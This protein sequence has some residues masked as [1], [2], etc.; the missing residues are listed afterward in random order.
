MEPNWIEIIGQ[1]AG[2]LSV[3]D[4]P[5]DF[6][7]PPG[8]ILE[9]YGWLLV[10]PDGT[11][12]MVPVC[13]KYETG[14]WKK[15]CAWYSAPLFSTS[16]MWPGNED[17]APWVRSEMRLPEGDG[18]VLAFDRNG[19]SLEFLWPI[20]VADR[21]GPEVYWYDG[22]IAPVPPEFLEHWRMKNG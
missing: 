20:Q 9:D 14:W 22:P 5:G 16:H 11:I 2:I 13:D 19:Y 21:K 6:P 17:T 12:I 1:E 10:H 4:F 15:M 8:R 18:R 7:L 3:P